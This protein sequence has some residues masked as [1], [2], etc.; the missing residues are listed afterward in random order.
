[1]PVEVDKFATIRDMGRYRI[2]SVDFETFLERRGVTVVLRP[3]KTTSENQEWIFVKKSNDVYEIE[4]LSNSKRILIG[5]DKRGECSFFLEERPV[6]S[7]QGTK[8]GTSWKFCTSSPF[9]D[10]LYI[11]S[12][13]LRDS[14]RVKSYLVYVDGNDNTTFKPDDRVQSDQNYHSLGKGENYLWRLIEVSP[15]SLPDGDSNGQF[16]I[17]TLNGMVIHSVPKQEGIFIKNQREGSQRAWII[18]DLGNGNVTLY[19]MAE[20]KYLSTKRVSDTWQPVL[21]GT[22]PLSLAST[23]STKEEENEKAPWRIEAISEVSWSICIW[24]R[25]NRAGFHGRE[26][27]SLSLKDDTLI[28][29]PW[30]KAHNQLWMIEPTD[31]PIPSSIKQTPA[32]DEISPGFSLQQNKAYQ[33]KR[34]DELGGIRV[35]YNT[36]VNPNRYDATFALNSDFTP[37]QLIMERTPGGQDGEVSIYRSLGGKRYLTVSGTQITIVE[38]PHPWVITQAQNKAFFLIRDTKSNLYLSH[39]TRTGPLSMKSQSGAN[40]TTTFWAITPF[41]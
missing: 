10:Q 30:K 18:Q 21:S 35:A 29:K 23:G 24:R 39:N 26:Q 22:A 27:L 4:P 1:M 41:N 6:E 13:E 33:F 16:R 34:N 28:L 19:N 40:D 25:T 9:N 15:S 7:E 5:E 37:S 2:Q 8:T 36:T 20:N 14:K 3:L 17:R 31:A 38:D 11:V 12:N 32:D